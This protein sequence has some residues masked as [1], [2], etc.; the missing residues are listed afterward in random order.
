MD[1]LVGM[2]QGPLAKPR[3]W[4]R[5]CLLVSFPKNMVSIRRHVARHCPF[6]VNFAPFDRAK[7]SLSNGVK[8]RMDSFAVGAVFA[9]QNSI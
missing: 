2:G 6:C 8:R 1:A 4:S 3:P 9:L 5:N 7:N